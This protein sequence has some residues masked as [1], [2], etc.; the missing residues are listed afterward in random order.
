MPPVKTTTVEIPE[1]SLGLI[2]IGLI[3]T[4]PL[5]CNRMSEK[6]KR[7]LLL[8]AG[9]KTVAQRATLLKHHPL[10]EFRDSP[11]TLPGDAPTLLAVMA[12]AFKRAMR[13]AAVDV[14]GASKAQIG[15]LLWVRG[16]YSAIYGV[17]QLFM[18]ITRSADMNK[19]PDVRTRAIVPRWAAQL[20]IEFVT[21]QLTQASVVNLL[22]M[23]GLTIG[24]GDWRPE[25]GS[26][27]YG[28]FRVC[29]TGDRELQKIM[30][31]GGRVAQ[32][33]AMENPCPYN[34]ETAELLTWFDEEL[35]R[36]GRSAKTATR[37]N[38]SATEVAA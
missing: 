17:P 27:T 29:E 38:G 5:I 26:G 34:A 37:T 22:A 36:R 6:A 21:P 20:E 18:S 1:P 32:E 4:S 16:E 33:D 14:A 24:V 11:Y 12:S 35:T 13:D 9:R 10:Q 31:S 15:R 30:K 23:A 2:Q 25:K 19:T 28:Q 8:P 7:E 3:G